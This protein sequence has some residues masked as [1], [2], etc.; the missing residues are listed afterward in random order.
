MSRKAKKPTMSPLATH[1]N[2]PQAAASARPPRPRC[3]FALRPIVPAFLRSRD[4]SADRKR[5]RRPAFVGLFNHRRFG[6]RSISSPTGRRRLFPK[7]QL[8][9]LGAPPVRRWAAARRCVSSFWQDRR[10]E[11]ERKRA[12]CRGR[13]ESAPSSHRGMSASS[14]SSAAGHRR[15]RGSFRPCRGSLA[16]AGSV[17]SRSAVS[18]SPLV[19]LDEADSSA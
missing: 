16:T 19:Q 13:M 17:S 2:S 8:W 5:R 14:A 1:K 9:L 10:L 7:G 6:A 18:V 4:K 15:Y 12:P 3:G 11:G